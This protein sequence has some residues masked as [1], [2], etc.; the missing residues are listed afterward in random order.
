M[1]AAAPPPAPSAADASPNP[2]A[3]GLVVPTAGS[4]GTAIWWVPTTSPPRMAADTPPRALPCWWST[5]GPAS[6]R[7]GVTGAA[8]CTTGGAGP[9]RPRAIPQRQYLLRGVARQPRSPIPRLARIRQ[10]CPIGQTLAEGALGW[11][12]TTPPRGWRRPDRD[13]HRPRRGPGRAAQ[14]ARRR[15][16]VPL[17]WRA[18][19]GNWPRCGSSRRRRTCGRSR[20]GRA[21]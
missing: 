17:T 20:S 18:R 21:G 10:H 8:T 19:S 3:A 13:A 9:A 16:G 4:R 14:T 15:E 12:A 11:L 5:V 7:H 6:C 1:S 2:R